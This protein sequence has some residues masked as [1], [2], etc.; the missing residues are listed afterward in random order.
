MTDRTGA[1]EAPAT[2]ATVERSLRSE[3]MSMNEYVND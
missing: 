1:R 2:S 3:T